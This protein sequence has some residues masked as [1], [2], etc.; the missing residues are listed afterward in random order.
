MLLP[1]QYIVA[2]WAE[3]YWV[4][5][6]KRT[7]ISAIYTFCYGF[8]AV[9]ES[10]VKLALWD[11]SGTHSFIHSFMHLAMNIILALAAR[12]SIFKY[13]HGLNLNTSQSDLNNW[14]TLWLSLPLFNLIGGQPKTYGL[15]R[16]AIP[17]DFYSSLYRLNLFWLL[18][19]FLHSPWMPAF[20][21]FL[22]G[23]L[24]CSLLIIV[25]CAVLRAG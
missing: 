13:G 2:K 11:Y 23:R 22:C 15:L 21:A 18:H 10:V 1:N 19:R 25:E 24:Q 6:V 14:V 9:H 7:S 8:V 4:L 5:D 20:I 16:K 12:Q 17:A 3:L